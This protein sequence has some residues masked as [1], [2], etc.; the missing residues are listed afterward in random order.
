MHNPGY[1]VDDPCFWWTIRGLQW[2]T[3]NYL[4]L[5]KEKAQLG[6]NIKA[7]RRNLSELPKQL[8]SFYMFKNYIVRRI[9]QNQAVLPLGV[10]RDT[11][12]WPTSTMWCQRELGGDLHVSKFPT[13][14]IVVDI[15]RSAITFLSNPWKNS[16]KFLIRLRGGLYMRSFRQVARLQCLLA[17]L[18]AV[19]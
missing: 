11:P 14:Q 9:H 19:I 7:T 15:W 5:M 4:H 1:S 13:A 16:R 2:L 8:K 17:R 10:T 12:D 18:L 3:Q 6:V